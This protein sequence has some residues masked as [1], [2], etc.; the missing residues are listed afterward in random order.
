MDPDG[1]ISLPFRDRPERFLVTD[2]GLHLSSKTE[3]L[4]EKFDQT[5]RKMLAVRLKIIAVPGVS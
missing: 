5:G 1:T 2:G 4:V 3:S